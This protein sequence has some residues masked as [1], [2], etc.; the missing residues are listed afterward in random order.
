MDPI[1]YDFTQAKPTISVAIC[2]TET[3]RAMTG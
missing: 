3:F 1:G 2:A